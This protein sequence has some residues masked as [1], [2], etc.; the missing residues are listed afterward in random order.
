MIYFL[1]HFYLTVCITI[2]S[3]FSILES[4]LA[5][6]SKVVDKILFNNK[7]IEDL[8]GISQDPPVSKWVK[9]FC[10]K[11]GNEYYIEVPLSFFHDPVVLNSINI[12]YDSPYTDEG[13]L[14]YVIFNMIFIINYL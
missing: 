14:I 4:S 9:N 3:T 11:R 7:K 6:D 8:T 2:F 12:L 10:S 1:F 5:R 13:N